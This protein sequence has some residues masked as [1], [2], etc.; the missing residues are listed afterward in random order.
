MHRFCLSVIVLVMICLV[1]A[2]AYAGKKMR[3][4]EIRFSMGNTTDRDANTKGFAGLNNLGTKKNKGWGIIRVEYSTAPE[5]ID[6]FDLKL[7]VLLGNAKNY[8]MLSDTVQ[9]MHVARGENHI[10]YSFIHPNIVA[11]F[12]EV[13][14]VRAEV[15][16]GGVLEDEKQWP[17]E[18][19]KPWWTK[20]RPLGGN[21]R[22][23]YFTPFERLA[24]N[25]EPIKIK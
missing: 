17:S 16:L 5:W 10:A 19:S 20:I 3:I 7:Y 18:S 15:W 22:I 6:E 1:P 11:R 12:G 23:K 13:R 4:D 8:T 25:E 14:R 9:Y 24:L 21:L 2:S